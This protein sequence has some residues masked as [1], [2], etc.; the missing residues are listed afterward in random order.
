[1]AQVALCAALLGLALVG[2]VV[3]V[4]S[5]NAVRRSIMLFSTY[6][7]SITGR[8]GLTGLRCA[9]EGFLCLQARLGLRCLRDRL[10]SG[11]SGP[12]KPAALCA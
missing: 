8:I 2:A 11:R 4:R 1:L 12:G 6:T 5:G 10:G 3:I 7:L 9:A